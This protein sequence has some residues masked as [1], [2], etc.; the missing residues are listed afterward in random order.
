MTVVFLSAGE[1]MICCAVPLLCWGF[2]FVVVVT[3]TYAL[4]VVCFDVAKV[5]RLPTLGSDDV[6]VFV[7]VSW[8]NG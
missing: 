2:F 1:V 5:V 6:W 7:A 4:V 3:F 8:P